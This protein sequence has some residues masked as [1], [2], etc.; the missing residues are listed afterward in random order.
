[1]RDQNKKLEFSLFENALDSLNEALVYYGRAEEGEQKA[2]KFCIQNLSHFFELILKYYVTLAHPLLIFK[3]PFQK[4]LNEDSFTITLNDAVNFLNNEGKNLSK[5]FVAD[6]KWMK[7]LRNS[8]EHHKF[9]ME[10]EEAQV[11]IGRLIHSMCVFDSKNENI[12]LYDFVNAQ[13]RTL[14]ENLSKSYE[15]RLEKALE[16]VEIAKHQAYKGYQLKEYFLVNFGVYNCYSCGNETVIP[17][18]ESK[19]GYI[20]TFCGDSNEENEEFEINC[21]SCST[22][23]PMYDLTYIDWADQGTEE[24]YCPV[25]LRHPDYVK[26]D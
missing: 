13:N 3:N 2:Y 23:W 11:T 10:I 24:P 9:S 5:S 26:D 6:L 12:N 4:G 21:Y 20:C 8:I 22:S 19:S 15:I 14:F 17:N 7:K 25:C 16:E 1:M 18:E